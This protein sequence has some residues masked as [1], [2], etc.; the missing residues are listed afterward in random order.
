MIYKEQDTLLS[1]PHL[2][3]Q[4][5]TLRHRRGKVHRKGF[6][7]STETFDARPPP[8]LVWYPVALEYKM[9]RSTGC[10]QHV[11]LPS[12]SPFLIP[13]DLTGIPSDS[14]RYND[15]SSKR[16]ARPEHSAKRL[17]EKNQSD[18][19]SL[20]QSRLKALTQVL[21]R[22]SLVV[23]VEIS[24]NS[25]T[26]HNIQP[27]RYTP[28]LLSLQPRQR[29]RSLAEDIPETNNTRDLLPFQYIVE[30]DCLFFGIAAIV[31][32]AD[33]ARKYDAGFDL[34]VYASL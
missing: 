9:L 19:S 7:F 20:K 18:T 8:G 6:Y 2:G 21:Q 16:Q 14:T 27:S 11:E 23:K 5:A 17:R 12:T 30:S 25:F 28:S 13:F 3:S 34:E 4:Y 15:G 29:R 31:G 22:S 24:A 10:K 33:L 32:D 1:S 26:K